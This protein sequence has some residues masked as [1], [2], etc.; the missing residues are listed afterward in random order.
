MVSKTVRVLAEPC[1]RQAPRN[2]QSTL[3]NG[4][5]S[6]YSVPGGDAA[7]LL[8]LIV[9][10]R[11]RFEAALGRPVRVFCGHEAGYDGF[12]LHRLLVAYDVEN[13]VLDAASLPIDRRARRAKTDRIDVDGLVRALAVYQHRNGPLRRVHATIRND[14]E[15]PG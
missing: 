1:S 14:G 4:R 11:S 6:H 12:W 3:T 7:A 8:A 10:A 13:H 9:Q 15:I 2:S 5:I